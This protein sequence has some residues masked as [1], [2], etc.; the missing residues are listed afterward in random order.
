MPG[1]RV[2]IPSGVA[3]R[4]RRLPPDVKRALRAALTSLSSDP[5]RGEPLQRELAGFVKFKVRRYRIVYRVEARTQTV[6]ILALRHRSTIYEEA[7][8]HLRSRRPRREG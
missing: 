5:L 2:V 8:E 1:Y 6:R 7:A 3:Q 4:I